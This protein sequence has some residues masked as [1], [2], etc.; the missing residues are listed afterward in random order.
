MRGQEWA[1]PALWHVQPPPPLPPHEH[2]GPTDRQGAGVA[3]QTQGSGQIWRCVPVVY[4]TFVPRFCFSLKSDRCSE[5][6]L[7]R[8]TKRNTRIWGKS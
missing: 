3:V 6:D 7:S 4:I 2:A 8:S 5:K 1:A